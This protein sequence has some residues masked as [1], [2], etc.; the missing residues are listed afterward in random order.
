MESCLPQKASKYLKK[1]LYELAD[2]H[3]C[4]GDV[5]CIGHFWALEIVKNRQTKEPFDV[6]ADKFSGKTLMTGKISADSMVNGLY[7]AAWYDTLIIAPP[8]I[9]NEEQIEEGISILD[10]SLKIGDA[11]TVSTDTPA[12]RSSDY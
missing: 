8:L 11:G 10:E 5:R 4:I 3:E 6:K 2:R 7:V 9:I 12:S 1:R